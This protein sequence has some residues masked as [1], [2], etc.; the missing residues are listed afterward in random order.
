R[1]H[2]E[3]DLMSEMYHHN[4]NQMKNV[5]SI[6]CGHDAFSIQMVNVSYSPRPRYLRSSFFGN[7]EERSQ[8]FSY[9][10]SETIKYFSMYPIHRSPRDLRSS[11][12][13]LRY[14]Y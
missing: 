6:S 2:P 11:F 10:V 14:I 4:Q 3:K 5:H 12:N 9:H 1:F 8:L 13:D 7:E